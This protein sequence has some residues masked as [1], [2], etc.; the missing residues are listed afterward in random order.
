M[1]EKLSAFTGTDI[2]ADR[3]LILTPGTQG[4]LSL[5]MGALVGRSGKAA[6]VEPDYFANLILRFQ[7]PSK[8]GQ[9]TYGL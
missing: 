8:S 9:V 5:A 7:E 4:A 3:N 1:A 6:I 2:D